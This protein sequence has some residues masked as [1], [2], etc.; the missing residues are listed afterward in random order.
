MS[1]NPGA[2]ITASVNVTSQNGA[3]ERWLSTKYQI[4]TNTAVCVNTPDHQGSTNTE[5]FSVTAPVVAGSYSFKVWIYS[6]D[7]CTANAV[8]PTTLVTGISVSADTTPPTA[9]VT[10]STSAPTN[11]NV[12]ATIHPSEPVTITNNGGSDF[13]TF[14]SNGSFKFEFKDAANNTGSTTAVVTNIDKTAP[15]ITIGEYNHAPT[16]QDVVVTAST[17]EGTLNTTSHTFISNDS[18][19][20][21][22]V[23][24]AMNYATTTVTIN[25]IDKVAP[26]ITITN[27][28]S[29]PAQSKTITAL[30]NEGTL[31]M[32]VDSGSVCNDSLNFVAY[33]AVTFNSE[34]D[35]GKKVCYKAADIAGNTTY[36][37]SEAISGIDTTSPIASIEYSNTAWT[38]QS[39]TATITPSEDVTITNNDGSKS[40]TFNTSGSFTFE[41]VDAANNPG[42]ATAVVSNIDVSSPIT[43]ITSPTAGT[44]LSGTVTLKATASDAVSPASGIASVEFWYASIGT[45]IEGELSFDPETNTFSIPWNTTNV[46]KGNHSIWTKVCDIAGNCTTSDSVSV[47]VDNTAPVITMKGTSPIRIL[48]NQTYV[49]AGATVSDDMDEGLTVQTVNN[50][51]TTK[52][53]DYTVT[54]NATDSAGNKALE[55]VRKVSVYAGSR[56][57]LISG[58]TEPVVTGET[59]GSTNEPTT[60]P[61]E[62]NEGGSVTYTPIEAVVTPVSGEVL[63]AE[64]F[65][66]LKDM[67]FKSKLNPDVKELQNRLI[68]EGFM[69]TGLATG[70][71]G[72]T[73]KSAVIKYQEK[74][75]DEVLKPLGLTKGTGFVGPY[76]RAFLN[77]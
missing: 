5:T 66:F 68:S 73:T 16:N 31:T 39:V 41:F 14:T 55:V 61:T 65:Q 59:T 11:Q 19:D 22:A 47:A 42:T 57:P 28:G 32:S 20:F 75:A 24:A 10:Y 29:T 30:T 71:F 63:G 1:V 56:R 54:Y 35:N 33:D 36:S 45:K 72:T 2:S 67:M 60:Q 15:V 58:V 27:P 62:S 3:S 23:D 12:T 49:D 74:Y 6:D 37:V 18:F 17:N 48:R 77:K 76:T 51:D 13:Y 43:A 52:V 40:Y 38:N 69:A 46:E 50:V 8:G 34:S 53:G 9:T 21:V 70:Y 44:H 25:N 64:K 7:A 26:E 4:G